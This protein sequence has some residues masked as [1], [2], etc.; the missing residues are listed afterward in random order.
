MT[1]FNETVFQDVSRCE[2]CLVDSRSRVGAARDHSFAGNSFKSCLTQYSLSCP[3]PVFLWNIL[4]RYH[5]LRTNNN[6]DVKVSES[7]AVFRSWQFRVYGR[8]RACVY[9]G[10]SQKLCRG[11]LWKCQRLHIIDLGLFGRQYAQFLQR[12]SIACYAERCISYSKSVRLSV[13]LSVRLTVCLSHAGTVSKRLKLRSWG[14]HCRIA[15][16]L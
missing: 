11:F 9:K 13:C 12:V 1:L 16:W 10:I 3:D 14:L 2:P 6:N 4:N 15:S 8:L 7:A 5:G